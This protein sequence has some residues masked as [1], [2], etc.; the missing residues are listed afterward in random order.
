VLE[1][2]RDGGAAGARGQRRLGKALP[3]GD[4]TGA[5]ETAD[6]ASDGGGDLQ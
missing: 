6:G 1:V 3:G 2:I 5:D 4:G